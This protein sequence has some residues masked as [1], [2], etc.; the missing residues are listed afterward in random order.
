MMK[1][2]GR[3]K[4]GGSQETKPIARIL[5]KLSADAP[6]TKTGKP[7]KGSPEFHKF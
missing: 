7:I 5:E 1:L 6:H 3:E 4:N 2:I